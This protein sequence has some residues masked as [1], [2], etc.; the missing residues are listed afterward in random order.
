MEHK[1]S[2]T[3][4]AE[5]QEIFLRLEK[6]DD[7]FSDFD[8]RPYSRR[9]LSVDFLEEA[10]RAVQDKSFDGIEL[11]IHVPEKE[12][13]ESHEMVIRER[14]NAHFKRHYVLSLRDKRD[15]KKRGFTMVSF[16]VVFMIAA[17]LVAFKG[18]EE[19]MW[20]AFLLVFLEPAAWFFLWEGMDQVIF[21]SKA[22]DPE[23]NFYKKMA[24]VHSRIHFKSY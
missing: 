8:I 4:L 10:R 19:S 23:F 13:S 15:I 7:I 12:R 21:Q 20:T 6:Y 14:L 16:G 3:A 9:S 22:N 5:T 18:H 17:T 24:D 1:I 2:R 11:Y